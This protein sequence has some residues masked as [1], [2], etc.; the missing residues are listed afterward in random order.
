MNIE[1]HKI[2]TPFNRDV[3]G[4]KKLIEGDFRNNTV[5]YLQNCEWIFTE[6]VDGTNIR[7]YWDGH[8]VSFAGRTDRAQ[9]PANLV[10]RLNELFSSNE[11]EEMFEQ[12]FG[13]KEVILYGEGYG[14]GIQTGGCYRPNQDFILFDV[15]VNGSFLARTNVEQIA[16][17]FSI[18]AVPVVL[19]GTIQQAVDLI[20]TKPKSLI[21]E[22]IMEGVVGVPAYPIYD[23]SRRRIITKIKVCDFIC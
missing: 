17:A 1:Y 13:E 22:C 14:A 2:D 7:V 11:A 3:N 16:K 9:L 4:T 20:K 21:G 15:C 5:K 23:S 8:K 12:M 6:K 18:D 10:T 19:K